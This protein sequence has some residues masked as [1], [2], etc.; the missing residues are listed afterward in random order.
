[1]MRRSVH[2]VR[3]L[4]LFEVLVALSLIVLLVSAMFTFYW[5]SIKIR[6]QAA[7]NADRAQIA[8]QVLDTLAAELRGC[9]GMDEVGFP[10]EYRLIGDRR[11]MTF[12]T[13]ALPDK[14][15]YEFYR[16]SEDLPPAQH[17]LRQISY[18][19]WID[20][21]ETTEEGEPV[22]GGLLRIEKKTLNQFIIDEEDPLELRTDLWS[23]ELGY[24]EFRFF[25]GVE[26]DV[27]W[28]ITEG[29]SLPQ[30]VQITV[31]F[32]SITN[33]ELEDQDLD[34]YPIEEYPLGGDV[35]YVNRYS[36]I[37]R[38]PA[39]DR[40]FGSRIQRVGN[41]LTDQLGVEGGM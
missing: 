13:T 22:V 17:D 32:D 12:L 30:L 10:V 6:E 23:H 9:V 35:P 37:V 38:I 3:A 8:R 25:D 5:Q 4:T 24:I 2:R 19:L 40:M 15:Q 11:S 41:Q 18:E 1:M 7:L 31:G 34:E 29:N 28:D 27:L 16:E 36:T 14:H 21:E 26:W 39:A 20:P 33:Y